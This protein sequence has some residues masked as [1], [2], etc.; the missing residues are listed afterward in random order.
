[1]EEKK[2]F[3][4]KNGEAIKKEAVR[5]TYATIGGVIGYVVGRKIIMLKIDNGINKL[6][7]AKPELKPV[8]DEAFE[9]VK[10]QYRRG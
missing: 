7:V 8:W 10:E 9:A 1:M 6:F 4:E 2:G 3:W 5:I